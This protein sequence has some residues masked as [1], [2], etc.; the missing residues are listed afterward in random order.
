MSKT[1]YLSPF[2][3]IISVICIACLLAS[4]AGNK[5][6]AT[7]KTTT[8]NDNSY[9]LSQKDYI[10]AQHYLNQAQTETNPDQT[11]ALLIKSSEQLIVEKDYTRALWLANQLSVLLPLKKTKTGIS[12]FSNSKTQNQAHNQSNNQSHIQY[13]NQAYKLALVKAASLMALNEN[14]LA[15]EQLLLADN[16]HSIAAN[17]H[18]MS[19]FKMLGLLQQ[20]R[21]LTLASIDAKLRAFSLQSTTQPY[22]FNELDDIDQ[23]WQQLSQLSQWQL[24]QLKSLNPPHIKGWFQLVNYAHKFGSDQQKFSRYL[25]QWHRKYPDHPAKSVVNDLLDENSISNNSVQLNQLNNS[26]NINNIAVIL[27][28]SGKQK[29]AGTVAQQGI[30]A[31]FQNDTN[32]TLHFIDANKLDMTTLKASFDHL[33]IDYVIGPLLKPHVKAYLAQTEL[34]LPTLLLNLPNKTLIERSLQKSYGLL[35]HQ[36]ALSMRREDEAVQA[37]T[38]L[39]QKQYQQPLILSHQDNTS[40]RIT[41]AF[42]QQW[43]LITGK[44]PET[45]YVAKGEETQDKLKESLDV[46]LSEERIDDLQLRV[47]Q[48]LKTETRN[49][50]DVDMIY[51]VGSAKQTRLLKPY[52]DVN[53]SPF[54]ELIPI[55]GSSLSHSSAVDTSDKRDLTGL[56]FTEIPW[57]LSSTQQNKQ[58]AQISHQ[59]WPNRSDSLQRFFA[60]GFDSYSILDKIS[61]MKNK[62]YIRHFGQTGVLKLNSNNILTRSLLWGRYQKDK[63]HEIAME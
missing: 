21:K 61:Q 28:L 3:H 54:A 50:R 18:Q 20:F 40:K 51:L 47:K 36:V 19:Y 31:A 22:Q 8:Q 39:S 13:H 25:N 63:V 30:L 58:L 62:S 9:L 44:L 52:I 55:Y 4:C 15:Y 35:P 53:I 59:L 7:S 6:S 37:A 43:Q 24:N 46:L 32:K 5:Q 23:L 29:V 33:A 2:T 48:T 57:S 12:Q 38:T 16:F 49:R 56:V 42:T 17:A 1:N 45:V 34:T 60:M 11:L 27:P 26:N 10:S 14:E 41:K